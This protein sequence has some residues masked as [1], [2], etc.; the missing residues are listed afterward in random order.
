MCS[1]ALQGPS[2]FFIYL[3][4]N[5]F[6][7]LSKWACVSRS[8]TYDT[9]VFL[10]ICQFRSKIVK[11]Q[12]SLQLPWMRRMAGKTRNRIVSAV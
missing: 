4:D 5:S 1:I 9:R 3:E 7:I 2:V 12:H 10:H 11:I 8:T 6:N